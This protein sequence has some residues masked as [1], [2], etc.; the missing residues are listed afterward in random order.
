[1]DTSIQWR[2]RTYKNG[3]QCQQVPTYDDHCLRQVSWYRGFAQKA[4][5]RNA[6]KAAAKSGIP[7][8]VALAIFCRNAAEAVEAYMKWELTER[9]FRFGEWEPDDSGY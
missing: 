2:T 6:A 7:I 1:M 4:G 8:K 5:V 9:E 3:A